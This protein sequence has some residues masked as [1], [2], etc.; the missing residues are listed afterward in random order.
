VYNYTPERKKGR[1]KKKYKYSATR[2]NLSPP[3]FRFYP[4]FFTRILSARILAD[5]SISLEY[6]FGCKR[7]LRS[8]R[9]LSRASYE[10][11]KQSAAHKIEH[12]EYS[13]LKVLLASFWSCYPSRFR[14]K[15]YENE[16]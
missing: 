13:E 14:R 3:Q 15:I 7:L 9:S 5:K 8:L 16:E 6:I 10:W 1:V 11:E 4:Q 2:T 12:R